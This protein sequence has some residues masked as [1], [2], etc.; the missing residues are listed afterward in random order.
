MDS[1]YKM[2]RRRPYEYHLLQSRMVI[3]FGQPMSKR[4]S[5]EIIVI[6]PYIGYDWASAFCTEFGVST[7]ERRLHAE[8][9]YL[10]E[11]SAGEGV[12]P[13]SP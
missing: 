1:L 13:G 5:D 10:M 6:Y 4:R 3:D 2:R 7:R 12:K 9:S 11:I 8:N